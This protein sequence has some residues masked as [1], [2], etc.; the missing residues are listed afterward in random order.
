M[1]LAKK[2]DAGPVQARP[3]STVER[4]KQAAGVEDTME[5]FS[6]RLPRRMRERLEYRF[7]EDGRTLSSGIRYV[8]QRYLDGD[9]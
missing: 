9:S 6:M 2:S 5:T 7:K 3:R 8:L 1:P 4:V